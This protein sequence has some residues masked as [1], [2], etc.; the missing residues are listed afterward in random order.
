MKRLFKITDQITD[1]V[2]QKCI[3]HLLFWRIQDPQAPATIELDSPGG[4][5]TATLAILDTMAFVGYP[6]HT[7]CPNYAYGCAALILAKGS[8]G[9]RSGNLNASIGLCPTVGGVSNTSA[10]PE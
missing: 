7:R 8:K 9:C 5:V 3:A 6:V 1:N 2:A 4:S 10:S